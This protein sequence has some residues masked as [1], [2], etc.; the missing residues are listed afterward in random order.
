MPPTHAVNGKERAPRR[1][2]HLVEYLPAPRRFPPSPR[3]RRKAAECA[4]S[5][6]IHSA[7][8]SRRR[9]KPDRRL[10]GFGIDRCAEVAATRHSVRLG[11][12]STASSVGSVAPHRFAPPQRRGRVTAGRHEGGL[13]L[14]VAANSVALP[15]ANRDSTHLPH[16]IPQSPIPPVPTPNL[17]PFCLLRRLPLR[18]PLLA[19]RAAGLEAAALVCGLR[20]DGGNAG[21][22]AVL[23]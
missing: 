9:G 21:G 2:S 15:P 6:P 3:L 19:A 5:P 20:E 13:R 8:R 22:A 7:D 16:P 17:Q 4:P 14:V 12:T 23:V 11:R 18:Q 1:A 10:Q